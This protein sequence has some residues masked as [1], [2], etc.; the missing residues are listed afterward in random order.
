MA[1]IPGLPPPADGG[2][3]LDV[4]TGTGLVAA[5]L[6]RR[7]FRVTGVDQS[8]EMLA[9]ARRRFG[10][11]VELVEASAEQLPFADATLRP[12]H[13]HV[14]P[15]LRRRSWGDARESWPASYARAASS[16]RSS[17]ACRAALA[18]PA[19]ELYVRAGLPLAGRVLRNG[20]REV[21][22]FLGDSIRSFWDAYP[23]ERQ[24]ELWDAAGI[25]G[26]R[27]AT[28]EPRWRRGHV[29]P[30][31]MSVP[32]ARPAWYALE[33]G[34]WRDYV[35]LLHLPYTAWHLSYVVDRRLPRTGRR[36]G[37]ARRRGRGVRS[38]RRDRSTRAR[39]A[40]RTAAAHEHPALGA[41]RAGRHLDRRGLRDRCRRRGRVRALARPARPR[42]TLPR[43]RL[44]PRA[45]RWPLPLGSLVRACLGRIPGRLRL[46]RGGRRHSASTRSLP[47]RSPCCSRSRSAPSRTTC[48]TSA[49]ASPPSTES[50]S[51]ATARASRST[52]DGLI[53][54]EERGLRLLAAASVVLAAALVAFRI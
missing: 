1:A 36:L 41:G 50:S 24:L 12:P 23:L 20:W 9:V 47:R 6:R 17:S 13:V 43:P 3:V 52:A 53:V 46:R 54:A 34:G 27:R 35:T 39:R 22:D 40:Q 11:A 42:R 10:D 25:A 2:H 7:G 31:G 8:A 51:S 38:G 16:R 44:Q 48:A 29:G 32:S 5:E 18:R 33:T 45:P 49:A 30:T 19:W 28:A 21:G 37:T 15:S 14:P 26:R 4:A